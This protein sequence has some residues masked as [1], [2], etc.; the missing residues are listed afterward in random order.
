MDGWIQA[1]SLLPSDLRQDLSCVSDSRIEEIRLR[2]GRQPSYCTENRE[3]R[4]S[5]RLCR[6]EDLMLVLEKA[7]SA[8]FHTVQEALRDGYLTRSGVRIGVCG[9][10]LPEESGGGFASVSSLALRI[11]RECKG[12]GRELVP[13]LQANA[14]GGTLLL[15]PPGGGKTT[16]LREM[17]RCLSNGGVCIGVVDER[18]ELSAESQGIAAFDLGCRSDVLTG[19]RK[20]KGAMLLLRSMSPRLI[21]MDEIT[22][23]EDVETIRQVTG[24]GVGILATAHATGPEQMRV[25]PLY[26]ELLESGVFQLAVCIEGQGSARRFSLRELR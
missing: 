20:A 7:S 9:R 3:R 14:S 25:R 24:C 17:I 12:I 22:K 11:P 4:F 15:S 5:E 21:A 16:L 18:N 2:R 23:P 6:E 1:L 26:R 10:M 19:V 8:S 13:A